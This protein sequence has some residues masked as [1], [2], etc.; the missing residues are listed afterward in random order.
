M[1][2]ITHAPSP[3][4]S[5]CLV[6]FVGRSAIDHN[7][8]QEQ[9]EAYCQVLRDCGVEVRTL[10]VN[11]ELSDCAFIEDLAVVLDEV[12]VVTRPGTASRRRETAQVEPVLREYRPIEGLAAPATLEGGDVLRV[13]RM[14]LV[15]LSSRTNA[16][17]VSALGA[18]ARQFGYDVRAVP[19]H[20]CLHLKTACTALPDRRLLVNRSWVDVDALYGFDLVDVPASEAWGANNACIGERVISAA[21]H[22]A[23]AD[24]IRSLGFDVCTVELDEFAKAEGGVTCLSLLV[25]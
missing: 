13:G 25:T 24:L 14:L 4:M 12:A 6:T 2:A 8:A 21:A 16:A 5:E 1:L 3:A 19:V 17:G 11:R 23:T 22:P 9:H 7:R 15:G 20:G 10:D 18:V